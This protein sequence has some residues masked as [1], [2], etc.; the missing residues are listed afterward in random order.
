MVRRVNTMAD[1]ATARFNPTDTKLGDLQDA[2]VV[3]DAVSSVDPRVINRG[4]SFVKS[5]RQRLIEQSP[6]PSSSPAVTNPKITHALALEG[7]N[8]LIGSL[9]QRLAAANA[10]AGYVPYDPNGTV[11]KFFDPNTGFTIRDV[12]TLRDSVNK[13]DAE[14][15]LTAIRQVSNFAKEMTYLQVQGGKASIDELK[16]P[17]PDRAYSSLIGI[18]GRA[19]AR[20]EKAEAEGI[21]PAPIQFDRRSWSEARKAKDFDPAYDNIVKYLETSKALI[22]VD[23][24]P[25]KKEAVLNSIDIDNRLVALR[26]KPPTPAVIR[27][28]TELTRKRR[29]G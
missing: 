2:Q 3:Q 17:I 13:G 21:T 7:A 23:I 29:N 27:E 12:A 14:G 1:M 28:I 8:G 24:V 11:A 19:S 18:C 10:S 5:V 4:L 20:L 26:S 25:R 15:L 9:Y 22:M 16:L 6:A